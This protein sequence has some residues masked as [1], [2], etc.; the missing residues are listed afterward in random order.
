MGFFIYR[1]SKNLIYRNQNKVLVKY[2]LFQ[3]YKE[4]GGNFNLDIALRH[5]FIIFKIVKQ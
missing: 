3:I 1:L 5:Y 4:K 2:S